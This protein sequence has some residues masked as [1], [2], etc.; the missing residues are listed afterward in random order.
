MTPY[1][2]R[3]VEGRRFLDW[4]TCFLLTATLPL[5][6]LSPQPRDGLTYF[7]LAVCSFTLLATAY[8]LIKESRSGA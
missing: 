8:R 2:K 4:L 6:L 1:W 7:T 3:R 5:I